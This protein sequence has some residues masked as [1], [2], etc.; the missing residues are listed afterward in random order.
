MAHRTVH[1]RRQRLWVGAV[2]AAHL[3]QKRSGEDIESDGGAHWITWKPKKSR[4]AEPSDDHRFPWFECH[5]PEIDAAPCGYESVADQV[6]VSDG[7][8]AG[9]DDEV[10][11]FEPLQSVSE[12]FPLV[13]YGW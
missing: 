8:A 7:G 9:G 5:L 3:E 4:G 1:G 13:V 12:G 2:I 11:A 6:M 10:K